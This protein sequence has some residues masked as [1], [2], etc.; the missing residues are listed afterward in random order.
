MKVFHPCYDN[1]TGHFQGLYE[2]IGYIFNRHMGSVHLTPISISKNTF[3][4]YG[5]PFDPSKLDYDNPD[6]DK[7]THADVKM[8]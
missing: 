1:V 5:G 7:M 6:K 8:L 2:S 4:V 3:E